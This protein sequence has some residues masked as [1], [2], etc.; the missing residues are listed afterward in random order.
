MCGL[1]CRNAQIVRFS[2]P[3]RAERIGKYLTRGIPETII[4]NPRA[5]LELQNAVR[6]YF[7]GQ[8]IEFDRFAVDLSALTKFQQQV[9]T[10]CRGI[11][12]GQT[13]TYS[14]LAEQVGRPNAIRAAALALAVNPLPLII[15]CHRILR[16][17]GSL[18]GFSA[19][20]GVGTKS[21]LL[22]LERQSSLR[23]GRPRIL[24][25]KRMGLV[26]TYRHQPRR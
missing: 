22:E 9:L 7:Q 8:P 21:R 5:G 2:L 10:A 24:R 3:D 1:L 15:P 18:G 12:Y 20:G 23:P 19:A 26:G 16:K 6:K 17:D 25:E 13:G 14:E 11:I 4:Q